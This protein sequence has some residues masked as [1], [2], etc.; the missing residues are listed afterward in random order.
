V[1]EWLY[2][3]VAGIDQ[4]PGSVAF[5]KLR[6]RPTPGG[7]LSRANASQETVRGRGASG[8]RV[9]GT[10]V[11]V[12]VGNPPGSTADLLIPTSDPT[13]VRDANGDAVPGPELHLASGTYRFI[14]TR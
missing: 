3:G 12:D 2:G 5:R 4:A 7:R 11:G 14:A 1:G 6:L 9:D 13:S 8:W 10:G